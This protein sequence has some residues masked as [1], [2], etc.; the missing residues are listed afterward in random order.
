MVEWLDWTA[1]F[2]TSW[3]ASV[4]GYKYL[5]WRIKKQFEQNMADTIARW[6]AVNEENKNVQD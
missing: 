3:V 4:I 2:V 1:G 5:T 6:S